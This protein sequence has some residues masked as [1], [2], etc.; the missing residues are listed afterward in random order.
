MPGILAHAEFPLHTSLIDGINNE[1]EVIK[2]MACG[3]RDDEYVFLEIRVAYPGNARWAKNFHRPQLVEFYP[4][5]NRPCFKVP[6]IKMLV[7]RTTGQNLLIADL[8]S[9]VGIGVLA[10]LSLLLAPLC[11]KVV[12]VR[13]RCPST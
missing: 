1:I 13:Q 8:L 6:P 2:R 11:V 3:F 12:G 9:L 7:L 4:F 10:L 5:L